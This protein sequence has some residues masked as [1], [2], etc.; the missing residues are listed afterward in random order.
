MALLALAQR[1]ARNPGDLRGIRNF[2]ARR[3]K[4]TDAL[5]AAIERGLRLPRRAIRTPPKKPADAPNVDG[6][7][8]LCLA[9]LAQRANREDLDLTVL[10]TRDDVTR[11]V[12]GEPSRLSSGWRAALVGRE[13]CAIIDGSAALRVNGSELQLVDRATP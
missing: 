7:V 10:G 1:P 5:L 11:L 13:L 9:W 6:V 3:F 8:A 2:D 12:L 4:H